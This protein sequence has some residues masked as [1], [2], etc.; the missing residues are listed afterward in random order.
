MS[1]AANRNKGIRAA[2]CDNPGEAGLSRLHNDANILVLRGNSVKPKDAIKI[3]EK[4]FE[5]KF[6]NEARHK[7]RIKKLG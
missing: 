4:F 3:I 1:I 7:K 2:L 6:S 5:V